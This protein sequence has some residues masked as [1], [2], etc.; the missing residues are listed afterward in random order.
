MSKIFIYP[1]SDLETIEHYITHPLLWGLTHGDADRDEWEPEL[2]RKS[3]FLIRRSEGEYSEDVGIIETYEFNELTLTAHYY[4]DPNYWGHQIGY[5]A[6]LAGLDYLRENTDYTSVLAKVGK[7]HYQVQVMLNQLG[8]ECIGRLKNA[9]KCDDEVT[10][11][12]LFQ[13]EFKEKK[14]E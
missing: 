11:L 7:K 2:D 13:L 8:F 4:V 5:H 9:C 3:Y 6:T 12:F 10:D 14:E 1:T